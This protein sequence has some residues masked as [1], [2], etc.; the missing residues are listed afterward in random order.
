MI[1][2]VADFDDELGEIFVMEEEP[3]VDQLKDAI[4]RTCIAQTFTPVF[5]GSAFKNRGVQTLLDG[6]L[7]YLPAP[8]EVK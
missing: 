7:D 1:E 4:R 3:T 6:V 5:L 8:H 2:R